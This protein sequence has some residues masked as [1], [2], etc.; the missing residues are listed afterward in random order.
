MDRCQN[1]T[2]KVH[3]NAPKQNK[4]KTEYLPTN[5]QTKHKLIVEIRKS[6]SDVEK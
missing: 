5:S 3:G 4:K 6:R 2:E 1:E